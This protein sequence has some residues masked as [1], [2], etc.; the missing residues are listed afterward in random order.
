NVS[1]EA[2]PE[3]GQPTQ[4]LSFCRNVPSFTATSPSPVQRGP[5][6]CNVSPRC[7]SSVQTPQPPIGHCNVRRSAATSLDPTQ[8][9]PVC[10][11]LGS[12]AAT[13]CDSPQSPSVHCN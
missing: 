3:P 6:R 9:R 1:S 10:R 5:I 8:R 4:P 7:A 12:A 2:A 13:S 11:N